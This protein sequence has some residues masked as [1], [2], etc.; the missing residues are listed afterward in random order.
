MKFGLYTLLSVDDEVVLLEQ[1]PHFGVDLK[2]LEDGRVW[3]DVRDDFFM[4]ERLREAGDRLGLKSILE[5]VSE[6]TMEERDE[7]R[8]LI[9]MRALMELCVRLATFTTYQKINPDRNPISRVL[10][11]QPSQWERYAKSYARNREE[12][13]G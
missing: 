2:V 12:M 3:L 8:R 9:F 4:S 5:E 1:C 7:S 13:G 10:D 6:G 11:L